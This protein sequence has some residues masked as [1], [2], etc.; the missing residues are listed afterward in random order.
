M[1]GNEVGLER[2]H[3]P[4]GLMHAGSRSISKMDLCLHPSQLNARHL[5]SR[6]TP[7]RL[8]SQQR[9]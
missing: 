1:V 2:G 7:G 9:F 4:T 3:L 5:A 6:F 8:P